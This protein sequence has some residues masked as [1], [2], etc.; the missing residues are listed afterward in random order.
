MDYRHVASEAL[1]LA[2]TEMETKDEGR[3]RYAAL[4]L[5]FA[6]EA[7]TYDR[8]KEYKDEFPPEEYETWQP[9]KVFR[10]LLEID[11]HADKNSE[12]AIGAESSAGQPPEHMTRLG[13][14]KVVSVA[15]LEKHYSALG[16][17]LHVPS[18]RQYNS[19]KVHDPIK[20]R[21]RC[22]EIAGVVAD[23]LTSANYKFTFGRF[24]KFQCLKCGALIRKR[25]NHGTQKFEMECF[26][27]TA[28]YTVTDAGSGNIEWEAHVY[29]I[30]CGG[31]AC[32]QIMEFWR[33]EIFDGKSW[34]CSKCNGQNT[35][36][37]S[38]QHSEVT[39]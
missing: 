36:V 29:N 8:A 32:E 33:S 38:L 21:R 4:E 1:N 7:L 27:C 35:V 23:V 37:Y 10:M 12:I 19:G 24:A 2:R 13:E 11:T 16:S 15:T 31:A 5:R 18:M 28:S 9:T 30:C 22:E 3:L 17:Y 25:I 6:L 14:K 20:L 26:S 34:I 39:N